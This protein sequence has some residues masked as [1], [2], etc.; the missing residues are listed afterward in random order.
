MPRK[1]PSKAAAA[2]EVVVEEAKDI[3][4]EIAADT[5]AEIAT[6]DVAAEESVAEVSVNPAIQQKPAVKM[7][8][9]C[10]NT[11][12]SCVIGGTRYYLRKDVQ[13]IVPQ[14]VKDILNKSGLLK[15]L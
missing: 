11:D 2:A 13:Q 3:A 1:F 6:D 12:H 15:P 10:P 8:K 5:A 9:I 4:E 14:E 7:V